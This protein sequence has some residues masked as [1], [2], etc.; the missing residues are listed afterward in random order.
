MVYKFRRA[1]F[2]DRIDMIYRI[3]GFFNLKMKAI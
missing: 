1:V 2:F 3:F